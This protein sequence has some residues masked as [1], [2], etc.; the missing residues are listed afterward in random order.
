MTAD[1]IVNGAVLGTWS[2][3]TASGP[4]PPAPTSPLG[5][6]PDGGPLALPAVERAAIAWGRAEV[7][8]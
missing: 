8:K 1:V 4:S 7:I 6:G 2:F 5:G 3:G